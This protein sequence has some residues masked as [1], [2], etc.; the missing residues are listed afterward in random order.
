ML[1]HLP[2]LFVRV[3]AHSLKAGF[4]ATFKHIEMKGN[5]HVQQRNR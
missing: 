5:C 3:A 1:L 4:A 2:D